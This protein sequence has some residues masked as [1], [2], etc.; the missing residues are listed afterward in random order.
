MIALTNP[1]RI[2]QHERLRGPGKY[3]TRRR[4]A[5]CIS[6]PSAARPGRD[7]VVSTRSAALACE[8]M[9]RPA[10]SSFIGPRASSSMPECRPTRKDR[11]GRS[12]RDG[13]DLTRAV[14]TRSERDD[15]S[16]LRPLSPPA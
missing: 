7:L 5:L 1:A 4:G 15:R 13:A 16:N 10:L 2:V 9:T 14:P 6:E 3:L 8:S 11:R 12:C